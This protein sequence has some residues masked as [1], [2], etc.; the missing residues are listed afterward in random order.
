MA[1]ASGTTG[2]LILPDDPLSVKFLQTYGATT[3]ERELKNIKT[4]DFSRNWTAQQNLIQV[5]LSNRLIKNSVYVI[6]DF[7]R[8][9][10]SLAALGCSG[11]VCYGFSEEDLLADPDLE[12]FITKL[13][14]INYCQEKVSQAHFEYFDQLGWYEKE[15]RQYLPNELASDLVSIVSDELQHDE[16]FDAT[17]NELQNLIIEKFQISLP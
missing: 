1:T 17:K 2:I 13:G 12:Q 14:M 9:R 8:S 5:L 3:S 15:I 6:N 4:V 7:Q 11:L 16:V 10:L